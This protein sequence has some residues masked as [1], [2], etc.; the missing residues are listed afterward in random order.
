MVKTKDLTGQIF[1]RWKVLYQVDDHI[2]P[3]GEHRP[4]WMCECQCDKRTK[5]AVDAYSLKSGNS[6][7]CGCYS[8]EETKKRNSRQNI[9]K[10]INDEYYIG[11]TQ[12]DKEFYFDKEDYNLVKDYCWDIDNSNGYAKTIDKINNTGKLYLHRLV[13]GCKK[14]DNVLIDHIN[15][16]KI[17]CRKNNLRIVNDIQNAINK[18]IKTNNTSGKTGVSWN[19]K[20]NKWESYITIN[21][22]RRRLGLFDNYNEAKKVRIEAEEK[23]FGEY[24]PILI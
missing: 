5:R 18:G 12:S 6:K 19:K 22:K 8:I 17:D 16:N 10:L 2:T 7:S 14:G 15:R 1:G 9:F 20:L 24:K 11:R 13:M 4:M 23:Y 21:K 3:K